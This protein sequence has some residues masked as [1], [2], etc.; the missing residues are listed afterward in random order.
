MGLQFSALG[1]PALEHLRRIL[2]QEQR[3][4]GPVE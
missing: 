3:Q 4:G 2:A 1:A